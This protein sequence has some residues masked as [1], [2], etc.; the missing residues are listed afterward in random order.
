[1]R[2]LMIVALVASL[3]WMPVAAVAQAPAQTGTG[4][5]LDNSRLLVIGLG[6]IGG[7]IVY[8]LVARAI[9]PSPMLTPAQGQAFY[10]GTV[11]PAPAAVP[12]AYGI[13]RGVGRSAAG[14]AGAIFGNWLYG[15]S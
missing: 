5:T 1:M 15:Q 7:L 14:V 3:A 11:P 13:F 9:G 12:A 8:N 2:K 4:Q 6:V 10:F